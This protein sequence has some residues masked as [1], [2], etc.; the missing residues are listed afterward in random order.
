[1]ILTNY[2]K[3]VAKRSPRDRR[4]K[5]KG[6]REVASACLGLSVK[7][8]LEDGTEI[9]I[10]AEEA[11]AIGMVQYVIDNPSPKN[12]KALQEVISEPMAKKEQEVIDYRES[13]LEG[14][15]IK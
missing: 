4:D 8:E 11:I 12:V 13:E 7:R 1:M 5:A 14:Q 6:I 3:S 9:N 15:E 2:E 10:S